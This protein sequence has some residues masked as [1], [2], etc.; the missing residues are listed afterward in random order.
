MTTGIV[1]VWSF[2]KPTNYF[3]FFLVKASLNA[4]LEEAILESKDYSKTIHELN[5]KTLILLDELVD[6]NKELKADLKEVAKEFH[7]TKLGSRD[8]TQKL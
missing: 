3:R 1:I 8:S 2:A 4:N 5:E 7:L 6:E